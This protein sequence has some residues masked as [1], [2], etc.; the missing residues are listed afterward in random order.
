MYLNPARAS[1]KPRHRACSLRMRLVVATLA[2]TAGIVATAHAEV[3]NFDTPIVVPNT[4]S[5]IYL[6]L[7][8]GANGSSGTSVPGWDFDPYNS[9]F[10]LAFFWNGIPAGSNAG[11]ST[12]V[13]GPYL[14]LPEGAIVSSAST[15]T[16][17]KANGQTAAF[18][19]AG[20]HILGF[21]FFNESTNIVNYGAMTLTA[22]SAT[23]FPLT[24][25]SWSFE[26]SGGP[27]TVTDP[28]ATR[29]ADG[30][31]N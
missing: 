27:F 24:I 17:L 8:T 31:E 18:Q 22:G 5:G 23:G 11:A 30:F 4:F 6:N 29:F 12:T 15:F 26:N 2:A 25:T 7:L 10:E 20:T 9:G 13:S 14:D 21:Q 1:A 16:T 3:V 19:S 28:F